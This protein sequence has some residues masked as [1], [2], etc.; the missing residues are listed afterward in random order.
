MEP[1]TYFIT[2]GTAVLGY[3]YY[4]LRKREYTFD[5]LRTVVATNNMRKNY[6]SAKFDVDNY[7]HTLAG[8]RS[9]DPEVLE[10][11][12]YLIEEGV[13]KKQKEEKMNEE[14]TVSK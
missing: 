1:V 8:L 6:A 2:F 9:Q 10:K 5:D 3:A 7:Y 12:E 13:L 4:A 14:Q 11:I